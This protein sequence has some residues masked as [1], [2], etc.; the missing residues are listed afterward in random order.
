[1]GF[2]KKK[3]VETDC[4][5]PG[6]L[7][8]EAVWVWTAVDPKTRLLLTHHVGG[9]EF[10]DCSR[11]VI[12]SLLPMLKGKLPLFVTYELVR[13]SSVLFELF[14]SETV[15]PR[16]GRRGRPRN[17]I[18]AVEPKLSYATVKKTRKCGNLVKIDR[19]VVFGTLESVN[20]NLKYSNSNTINT[21]YIERTNL[22]W[23]NCDAHLTRKTLKFV[24]NIS[25]LK[26]KLSLNIVKYNFIKP[27]TILT[28]HAN[29]VPT[30][31]A[32]AAMLTDHVWT[33]EELIEKSY[34]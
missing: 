2:R 5:T 6:S 7:F 4:Q 22:N 13:Y 27:H 24:K 15:V 1:L 20:N 8:E 26:A 11:T 30:T 31:P 9:H 34:C 17:P 16:T 29:K 21:S 18:V 12:S 28:K 3:C 14:H 10:D 25:Y 23:R 32:M 33:F 19:I